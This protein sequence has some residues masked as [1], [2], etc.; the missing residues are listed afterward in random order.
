MKAGLKELAFD[1]AELYATRQKQQGFPFSHDLPWQR[2]FE[3]MFPYELTEDQQKSVEQIFSDMESRRSMDRLLCGDVGY[4][5]TEVALRA[6]IQGGTGQQ[7][8]RH[9]RPHHHSGAAAL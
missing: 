8:G 9:P 5:K 4:G 6:R 1:L 7:A 3:D 2:E